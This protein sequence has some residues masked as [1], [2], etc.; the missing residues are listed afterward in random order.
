MEYFFT[1]SNFCW[2]LKTHAEY[3]RPLVDS[4]GPSRI[5]K[6]FNEIKRP[7]VN[8]KRQFIPSHVSV[9]AS[10]FRFSSEA[11]TCCI[12]RKNMIVH[13]DSEIDLKNLP[14][15]RPHLRPCF[16]RFL[17]LRYRLHK[18]QYDLIVRLA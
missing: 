6:A 8:A 9:C 18:H 10:K 7:L 16:L 14:N 17:G 12:D 5:Q 13:L 11:K 1:S 15:F 3:E 2:I 4:R